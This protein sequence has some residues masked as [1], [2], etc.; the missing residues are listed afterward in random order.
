MKAIYR[1]PTD[2]SD[3]RYYEYECKIL[4]FIAINNL[5]KAIIQVDNSLWCVPINELSLSEVVDE[6]DS[7]LDSHWLFKNE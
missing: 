5:P 7:Y 4:D 6:E 3:I 1:K 2:F